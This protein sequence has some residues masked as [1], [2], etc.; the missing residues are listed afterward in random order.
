MDKYPTN[1]RPSV[2]SFKKTVKINKSNSKYHI[3]SMVGYFFPKGLVLSLD[4]F[5]F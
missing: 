5:G 4:L 2:I 1:I 3:S